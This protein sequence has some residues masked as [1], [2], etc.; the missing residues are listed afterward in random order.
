MDGPKKYYGL[1]VQNCWSAV[2]GFANWNFNESSIE[3]RES[4]KLIC[5]NGDSFEEGDGHF[6]GWY[7]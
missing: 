6:M 3:P 2:N 4:A 7:L 5:E 1:M